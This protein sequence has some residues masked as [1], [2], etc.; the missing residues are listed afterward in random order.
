MNE[1]IHHRSQPARE[2]EGLNF[3]KECEGKGFS[4]VGC[5]SSVYLVVA[6]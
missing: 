4:R 1:V 2:S 5:Q 3:Y 6:C